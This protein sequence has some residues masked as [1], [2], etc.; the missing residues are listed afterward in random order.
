MKDFMEEFEE[1]DKQ[2]KRQTMIAWFKVAGILF[3]IGTMIAFTFVLIDG[4]QK[5][6]TAY[7]G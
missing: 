5:L 3:V 1:F 7:M 2:F 4:V 6:V